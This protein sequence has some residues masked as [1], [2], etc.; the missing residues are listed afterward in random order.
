MFQFDSSWLQHQ[1]ILIHA[2]FPDSLDIS[3]KIFEIKGTYYLWTWLSYEDFFPSFRLL[4]S[5]ESY[6]AN[7]IRIIFK[8]VQIYLVNIF[9]LQGITKDEGLNH[10]NI[11][12]PL[13][14]KVRQS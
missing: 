12:F 5:I 9:K 10:L 3:L 11:F 8:L 7:K 1:Q 4:S 2:V 14:Q 13:L 6:S